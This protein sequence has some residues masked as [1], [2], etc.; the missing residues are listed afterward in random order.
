MKKQKDEVLTRDH[1]ELDDILNDAFISLLEGGRPAYAVID[2]FWARLAVHIRA[3]HLHLFPFLVEAVEERNVQNGTETSHML[4]VLKA[5]HNFFMSD[6]A[7]I[8]KTLRDRD[9]PGETLLKGVTERLKLVQRRLETHNELEETHIYPL[10]EVLLTSEEASKLNL[11]MK[12]E[13]ENLPARFLDASGSH[14]G[15]AQ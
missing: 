6:L 11:R 7:Q 8:V 3:E 14:S 9:E 15:D 12:R 2:Y 13:L 10:V 5:D 4:D 1:A